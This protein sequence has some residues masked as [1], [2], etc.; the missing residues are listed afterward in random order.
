[1]SVADLME[2]RL[3]GQQ[4]QQPV[5]NRPSDTPPP[6][7]GQG[8]PGPAAAV[9]QRDAESAQRY[10]SGT[11][12]RTT[13]MMVVLFIAGMGWIFWQSRSTS[14]YSPTEDQQR[15]ERLVRTTVSAMQA[16]ASAAQKP[17]REDRIQ[18]L[19]P[20]AA[21][22]RQVPYARLD[23]NPFA[24]FAAVGPEPLEELP[25]VVIE[26]SSASA[27]IESEKEEEEKPKAPPVDSLVLQSVMIGASE[28][29]LISGEV[30]RPGQ[31]IK[32]WT[33]EALAPRS[34]VLRWKDETH[35]LMMP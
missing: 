19:M 5:P 25:Q 29:A 35:T 6:A 34:V 10:Q 4:A 23:G 31:Q 1:M 30:V 22:Q 17:G 27:D 9:Q 24:F 3:N 2:Q 26:D 33:L 14:A 21:E 32:G 11:W 12:N 28:S 16:R 7:G 8:P 18:Q 15:S 13:I 20:L